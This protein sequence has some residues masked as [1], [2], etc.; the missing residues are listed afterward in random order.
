VE[1]IGDLG[2][3]IALACWFQF[4]SIEMAWVGQRPLTPD[5]TFGRVFPVEQ[6]GTLY[7]SQ[8]D[9]DFQNYFVAPGLIFGGVGFVLLLVHHVT[10]KTEARDHSDARLKGIA[11]IALI[12]FVA[13][14]P[15]WLF[16]NPF[17]ALAKAVHQ[18]R[19]L[20]LIDVAI[21]VVMVGWWMLMEQGT[22]FNRGRRSKF[23]G[24]S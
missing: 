14:L 15:V 20:L 11:N 12:A 4:G 19:Q 17:T 2:V 18:P 1:L 8:S 6:H 16:A 7:V 13:L 10:R 3:A 24:S 22:L 9:L 23:S 21:A 5:P